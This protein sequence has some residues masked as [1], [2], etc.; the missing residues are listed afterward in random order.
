M[1]EN[2]QNLRLRYRTV[3]TKKGFTGMH[4]ILFLIVYVIPSNT[5]EPKKIIN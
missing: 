1:R 5:K 2:Q 3:G 4:N